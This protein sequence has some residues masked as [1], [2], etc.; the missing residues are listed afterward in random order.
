MGDFTFTFITLTT[1]E[2]SSCITRVIYTV[3]PCDPF[4]IMSYSHRFD[5]HVDVQIINK[6][7]PRRVESL[8]E[9]EKMERQVEYF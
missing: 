8:S 7:Q 6:Q 2:S 9:E 5:L 3:Y 1:L 4:P